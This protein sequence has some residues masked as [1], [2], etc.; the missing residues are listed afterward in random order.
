MLWWLCKWYLIFNL[1]Q[2]KLDIVNSVRTYKS[3]KGVIK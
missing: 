1:N 3:T 2:L